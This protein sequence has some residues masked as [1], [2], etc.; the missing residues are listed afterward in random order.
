MSVI[1]SLITAL[2][3]FLIAFQNPSLGGEVHKKKVKTIALLI[4]CL[5]VLSSI[6]NI[7]F[8]FLVILPA[9]EVGVVETFGNVQD[10]PL[11]SGI[12]FISPLAK[13]TKFSTRLQDIKETV[14]ATS[15]EC[16]ASLC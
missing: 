12:H 8:R 5:A 10:K 6:Y 11:N 14:D 2:V 4:G 13:V 16:K 1:F 7:L 3:A 9:G 15:K